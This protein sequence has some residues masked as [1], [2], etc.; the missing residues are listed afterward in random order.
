MLGPRR[1]VNVD[2]CTLVVGGREKR[3]TLRVIHMEMAEEQVQLFHAFLIE[4]QAQLTDSRT[5]VQHDD[6]RSAPDFDARCVATAT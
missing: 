6:T 3:E 1:R 5:C 2:L 4:L